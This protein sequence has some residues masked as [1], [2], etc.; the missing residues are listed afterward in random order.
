MSKQTTFGARLRKL[1]EAR[2]LTQQQV[3]NMAEMQ[4]SA[5]SHFEVDERSPSLTNL[6]RLLVALR[7]K[8]AEAWNLI[9]GDR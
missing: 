5:V 6:V 8:P 1:R 9:M 3:A 7:A 4:S 2:G